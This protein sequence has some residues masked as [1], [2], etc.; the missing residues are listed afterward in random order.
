[1][2]K[3]TTKTGGDSEFEMI[4]EN[5]I[6]DVLVGGVEDNTFQYNGETVSK[7]RWTFTVNDNGKFHGTD[8]WGDTSQSFV[9]HPNCKA[10]NWAAAITGRQYEGGE[11][12]DT[13]D[14][15]GLPCRIMIMHK[16]DNKTG[17]MYMRAKEVF[18]PSDTPKD[19]T[20][21]AAP[22]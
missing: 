20:P 14:L 3:L 7:L 16:P 19:Q 21:E 9:S 10:Y 12:L 5:D 15:L 13:D 18:A 11:A 8:I 6:V 2:V 17:N 22:F 4:R 1:M